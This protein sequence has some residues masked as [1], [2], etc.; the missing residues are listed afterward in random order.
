MYYYLWKSG[1]DLP[2]AYVFNASSLIDIRNFLVWELVDSLTAGEEDL[3]GSNISNYNID[4]IDW[5]EYDTSI[6]AVQKTI[7][8][9]Y[10]ICSDENM[11]N[12]KLFNKYSDEDEMM[13]SGQVAYWTPVD[14]KH[15]T[16]DQESEFNFGY[17][18]SVSEEIFDAEK[19]YRKFLFGAQSMF[20]QR[21]WL[22]E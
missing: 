14:Y 4:Q 7:S 11:N 13:N 19:H 5:G 22:L 1:D 18:L 17:A 12:Y 9:I 16:V 6:E 21:P 20:G 2:V 8:E 15:F 10:A 3:Q